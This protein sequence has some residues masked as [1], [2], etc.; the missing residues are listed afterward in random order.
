M[1]EKIHLWNNEVPN[2]TKDKNE[3]VIEFDKTDNITRITEVTNPLIEIFTPEKK[4]NN[5]KAILICP[6]GAYTILALDLEGT[7]P[8]LWLT[9]LGYTT[10]VLQYRVPDNL[11][12]A[13]NDIQRAFK[14]IKHK[15]KHSKIGV[16][17]FSAGANLAARLSTNFSELSYNI[18]DKIDNETCKPDFTLLIYPAYLDLGKDYTVS[19]NLLKNKNLPPTFI[20]GTKDDPYFNSIPVFTDYLK[21]IDCKFELQIVLKGNHGYGIRKGNNAAEKWP[22]LAEKW[23][24]TITE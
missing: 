22:I 16:L 15:F 8:A 24:N 19:P 2:K 12:G 20:F 9:N 6:G 7:E 23:L 18:V 11:E 14:M 1:T 10:Y 5:R 21:T 3:P 17:G 13:F 4:I